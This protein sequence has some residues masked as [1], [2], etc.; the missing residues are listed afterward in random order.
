VA[1]ALRLHDNGTVARARLT[2]G[3][4]ASHP[5]SADEAVARLCDQPPSLEL[6]EVVAR[7]AA[8]PAKPLDNADL[9][10]TYRKQMTPVFVRRALQQLLADRLP[11]AGE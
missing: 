4:V 7:E 9:T 2:L 5:L 10:M 6:L 3:A 11:A 1:A 8:R